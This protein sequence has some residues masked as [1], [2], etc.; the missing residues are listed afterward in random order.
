VQTLLEPGVVWR[1]AGF[2]CPDF[3]WVTH[4]LLVPRSALG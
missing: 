1:S 4:G 3:A 2:A